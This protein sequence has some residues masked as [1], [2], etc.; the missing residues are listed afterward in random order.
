MK[1]KNG[2]HPLGDAAQ[3]IVFGLFM[4]MLE[5]KLGQDYIAYK[6]KT[7]K[8]IPHLGTKG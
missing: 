7:G 1:D 5:A 4:V 6:K 2:E 3:L 8:W